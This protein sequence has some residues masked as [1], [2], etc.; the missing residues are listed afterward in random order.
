MHKKILSINDELEP[1][2]FRLTDSEK[3]ALNALIDTLSSFKPAINPEMVSLCCRIASSW[4]QAQRFP[5]LDLLRLIV[6]HSSL[7]LETPNFLDL[8]LEKSAFPSTVLASWSKPQETNVMIGLRLLSN[9]SSTSPGRTFLAGKSTLLCERIQYCWQNSNLNCR[10]GFVSLLYN[11]AC[12][13]I[14]DSLAVF[15]T[16][17]VLEVCAINNLATKERDRCR[18]HFQRTGRFVQGL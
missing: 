13:T 11:L 15:I 18:S 9:L 5:G 14:D 6:L 1:A 3:L 12:Y 2:E 8:L 16:T 10:I 17:K 4:P 7:P